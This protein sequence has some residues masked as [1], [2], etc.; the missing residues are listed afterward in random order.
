MGSETL[1]L[2]P[3]LTRLVARED[4]IEISRRESFKSYFLLKFSNSYLHVTLN[5]KVCYLCSMYFLLSTFNICIFSTCSSSI[6]FWVTFT[7]Y[8]LL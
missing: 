3:Q 1:D 7:A 5:V 4:F 8:I 2:Y 6:N